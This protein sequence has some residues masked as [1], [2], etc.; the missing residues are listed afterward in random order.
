MS[1]KQVRLSVNPLA[2]F[3][4][5][6]ERRKASIIKGQKNPSTMI[7]S[8][9]RSAKATMAK[10]YRDPLVTSIIE[11]GLRNLKSKKP[12]TDWQR[13]N[14]S[15]SIELLERFIRMKVP[16]IFNSDEIE[17]IKPDRKSVLLYGVE[18]ITSPELV[19]RIKID[20]IWQYGAVKFHTSKS[21]KFDRTKAK[22]VS[23]VLKMYLERYVKH[24]EEIGVVNPNYCFCVD[25]F[26]E[27]ITNASA[28]SS[29]TELV[30]NE[31]C[32][33]I[34]KLWDAA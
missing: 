33:E 3:I 19:Y 9:Y 21:G 34:I 17:F 25:V 20:G 14:T 31:A 15:G 11:E 7:V 2:E 24:L 30:I 1:K 12:E 4:Y 22:V 18:I 29:K 8:W 28:E 5:A 27:I 23:T 6:S 16:K 32:A 10:Y 13:S 26:N